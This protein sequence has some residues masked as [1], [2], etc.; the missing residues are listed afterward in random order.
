MVV[1]H[2]P[3]NHH[4]A[5]LAIEDLEAF[6]LS[7]RSISPWLSYAQSTAFV[8]STIAVAVVVRPAHSGTCWAVLKQKRA[9]TRT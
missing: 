8:A 4:P 6:C 2:Y 9:D 1:G 3:L 5:R 7:W